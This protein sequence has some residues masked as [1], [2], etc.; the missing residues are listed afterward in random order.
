M[1]YGLAAFHGAY[2]SKANDWTDFLSK[3][4]VGYAFSVDE[5]GKHITSSG[6]GFYV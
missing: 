5:I 4:T 6:I 3:A 1:L 2:V